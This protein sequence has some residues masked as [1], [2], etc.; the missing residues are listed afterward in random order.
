MAAW[1]A[2]SAVYGTECMSL[3]AADIQH[4]VSAELV[5]VQQ[6]PGDPRPW[7]V[8]ARLMTLY[9]RTFPGSDGAKVVHW[10]RM[11]AQAADASVDVDTRV[12]SVAV[13]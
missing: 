7:S 6:Q 4:Q 13:P 8:V 3:G 9:A 1:E 11:A 12:W 10:Y 2:E 5:T